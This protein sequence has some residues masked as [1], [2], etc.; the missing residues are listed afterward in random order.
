MSIN[1]G[2]EIER[3]IISNLNNQKITLLPIE[4]KKLMA[5]LFKNI[6][7]ENELIKCEKKEG[8]G[9]EKKNDLTIKFQNKSVNLS[10]KSGSANSV[11]QENIHSFIEFLNSKKEL[12]IERKNLIYEFHWCDGTLDNTG[13][14]E[15]RKSKVEYK[16][17][18]KDKYARYMNIL[19]EYK[20]EIF[21]RV[22]TGSENPPDYTVYFKK[23]VFFVLD[24]KDLLSKHLNT[25]ES[26]S[27][28]GILTVQNWNACLQ[29]QDL[30]GSKHRNDIQFKC[31]DF[32]RHLI[33]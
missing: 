31:K 26:D 4:Y 15:D 1:K 6:G 14:I 23:G 9:L 24:F 12:E 11:H 2:F 22:F 33:E 32:A 16:K 5:N 27:N 30:K 19:R 28:L 18:H 3:E 7:G 29:G 13:K 21:F 8:T 20:K 25:K 10:I 17:T